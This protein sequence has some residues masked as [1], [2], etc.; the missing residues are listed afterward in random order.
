[1]LDAALQSRALDCLCAPVTC[2]PAWASDGTALRLTLTWG[3]THFAAQALAHMTG[4]NAPM[5]STLRHTI[6]D[7][8]RCVGAAADPTVVRRSRRAAARY[9]AWLR[10]H[11]LPRTAARVRVTN[12]LAP[13]SA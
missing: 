11:R 10:A 5:P 2:L 7:S 8:I 3:A 6:T 12:G 4:H 13:A 9:A 1:M